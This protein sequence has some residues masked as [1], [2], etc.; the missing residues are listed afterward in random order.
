MDE[1]TIATWSLP[2]A[3]TA[4]WVTIPRDVAGGSV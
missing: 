3:S 4:A 2:E 1:N